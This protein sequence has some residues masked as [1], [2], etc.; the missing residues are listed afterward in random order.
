MP[1]ENLIR[2]IGVDHVDSTHMH[3]EIDFDFTCGSID[4][5]IQEHPKV[6]KIRNMTKFISEKI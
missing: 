6:E 4:F 1:K 5:T 2:N 3:G